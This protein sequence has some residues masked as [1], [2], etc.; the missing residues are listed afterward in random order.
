[1]PC[2]A[3]CSK[4]PEVSRAWV[5]VLLGV[6]GLC[7]LCGCCGLHGSTWAMSGC[8][9]I[10]EFCGV[11]RLCIVLCV[12]AKLPDTGSLFVPSP[13]LGENMLKYKSQRERSFDLTCRTIRTTA[14]SFTGCSATAWFVNETKADKTEPHPWILVKCLPTLKR[15]SLE[16]TEGVGPV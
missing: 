8:M 1:M 3:G 6:C 13:A 7:G 10:C 9:A 14:I 4:A 15:R 11:C 5:E 12:C 16:G 2:T